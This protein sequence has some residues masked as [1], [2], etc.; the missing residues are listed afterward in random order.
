MTKPM[1]IFLAALITAGLAFTLTSSEASVTASE[2]SE[3]SQS[4]DTLELI[5]QTQDRLIEASA[6]YDTKFTTQKRDSAIQI[7]PEMSA[8][9][10]EVKYRVNEMKDGKPL[11]VWVTPRTD[12]NDQATLNDFNNEMDTYLKDTR[13]LYQRWHE[14][15]QDQLKEQFLTET[16]EQR[17]A[18]IQENTNTYVPYVVKVDPECSTETMEIS[19]YKPGADHV[20]LTPEVFNGPE[21]A[22]R[23]T[24]AHEIT[25]YMQGKNPDFV[26]QL[27]TNKQELEDEAI[28]NEHIFGC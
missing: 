1:T 27:N 12:F 23:R 18:R 3:V 22:L 17:M 16:P 20:I 2:E 13:K 7:T 21:C 24:Y 10:Q 6:E 26:D 9:Y 15:I 8:L 28:N 25:H 11:P 5:T 4:I 14:L 19:C